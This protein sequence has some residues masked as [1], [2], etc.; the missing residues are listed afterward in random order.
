VSKLRLD[1][2][3]G[4]DD[5]LIGDNQAPRIDDKSG[6]VLG[7]RPQRDDTVLPLSCEKRRVRV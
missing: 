6:R 4:A 1:G 7:W 3:R 5:A 2:R